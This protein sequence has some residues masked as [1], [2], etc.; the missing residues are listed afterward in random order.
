MSHGSL[1]C[2]DSDLRNPVMVVLDGNGAAMP[3]T[4]KHHPAAG[5]RHH[6]TRRV[7]KVRIPLVPDIVPASQASRVSRA[8]VTPGTLPGSPRRRSPAVTAG[9]Q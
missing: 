9:N 5:D 8:A 6:R 3:A 1:G 4:I 2:Q 7:S